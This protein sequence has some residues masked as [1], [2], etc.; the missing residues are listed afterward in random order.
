MVDAFQSIPVHSP[1]VFGRCPKLIDFASRGD[2][3][4]VIRVRTDG[5]TC[6]GLLILYLYVGKVEFEAV[7]TGV[8]MRLNRLAA[9][10]ALQGLERCCHQALICRLNRTNALEV[11][12]SV[13]KSDNVELKMAC[14]RYILSH[15][16]ETSCRER[17]HLVAKSVAI[18]N[19]C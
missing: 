3:V 9:L 8:I 10:V 16:D 14:S 15:L 2:A 19:G 5:D 6:L 4:H 7:E 12:D 18:L 1:I 13:S 11:F 17:G